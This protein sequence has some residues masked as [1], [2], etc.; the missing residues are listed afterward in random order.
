MSSCSK[1]ALPAVCFLQ[2]FV[3]LDF[4]ATELRG[5]AASQSAIVAAS[6]FFHLASD[7]SYS[8]LF[9]DRCDLSFVLYNLTLHRIFSVKR[10]PKFTP[11]R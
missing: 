8:F 7:L 10:P 1:D 4:D 3:M 6:R 9:S 2:S 5:D 11:S